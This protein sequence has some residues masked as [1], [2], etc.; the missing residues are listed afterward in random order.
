MVQCLATY[1]PLNH[2]ENI[3]LYKMEQDKTAYFDC[4]VAS[5]LYQVDNLR[6]FDF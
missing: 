4:T 5:E 2:F 3:V 1:E 6:K